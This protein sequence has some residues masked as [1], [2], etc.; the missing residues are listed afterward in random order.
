MKRNY[1]RIVCIDESD[2]IEYKILEDVNRGTIED[3]NSFLKE[4]VSQ[5]VGNGIR[6]LL[7]PAT[8]TM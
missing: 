8:V 3:V 5:H 1:V 6:W 4:S 7:L 2:P